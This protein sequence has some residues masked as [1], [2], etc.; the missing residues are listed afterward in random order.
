MPRWLSRNSACYEGICY[1]A[2]GRLTAIGPVLSRRT[3]GTA[4]IPGSENST[5]HATTSSER[6]QFSSPRPY[7]SS[8]SNRLRRLALSVRRKDEDAFKYVL[9]RIAKHWTLEMSKLL[10]RHNPF[11][12]VPGC[13]PT[14]PT[15]DISTSDLG[16]HNHIAASHN[17]SK[18]VSKVR[19]VHSAADNHDP[20]NWQ[21]GDRRPDWQNAYTQSIQGVSP[22]QQ[23]IDIAAELASGKYSMDD[24][25]AAEA[26][27]DALTQCSAQ[28]LLT[29]KEGPEAE[30]WN[31][32]VSAICKKFQNLASSKVD[33]AV[34]LP[35]MCALSRLYSLIPWCENVQDTCNKVFLFVETRMDMLNCNQMCSLAHA[36]ANAQIRKAS[37]TTRVLGRVDQFASSMLPADIV[38][39]SMA[40][41]S[42]MSLDDHANLLKLGSVLSFVL[43]LDSAVTG[44]GLHTLTELLHQLWPVRE[45]VSC[46]TEL[47]AGLVPVLADRISMAIP[48][49]WVFSCLQNFLR[50][51]PCI[52]NEAAS[53]R[54][55]L[56]YFLSLCAPS[57]S[58]EKILLSAKILSQDDRLSPPYL[59]PNFYTSVVRCVVED[60]AYLSNTQLIDLL[61]CLKVFKMLHYNVAAFVA[62]STFPRAASLSADEFCQLLSVLEYPGMSSGLKALEAALGSQEKKT[63]LSACLPTLKLNFR[64]ALSAFLMPECRRRF[65]ELSDAEISS[66]MCAL[67]HNNVPLDILYPYLDRVQATTDWNQRLSILYIVSESS[68]GRTPDRAFQNIVTQAC[69]AVLDGLEQNVEA[70]KVVSLWEM[71]PT[72]RGLPS[73]LL[74]HLTCQLLTIC[75]TYTPKQSDSSKSPDLFQLRTL[76][77]MWCLLSSQATPADQDTKSNVRQQ[78]PSYALQGL[79]HQ[80]AVTRKLSSWSDGLREQI[81]EKLLVVNRA[82]AEH[83]SCPQ[84]SS[85]AHSMLE[86]AHQSSG[87]SQTDLVKES[88]RFLQ[89]AKAGVLNS[90][91]KCELLSLAGLVK[92]LN[93]VEKQSKLSCN[94]NYCIEP[95]LLNA[96][97]SQISHLYR[98]GSCIAY[99][100]SAVDTLNLLSTMGPLPRA[101]WTVFSQL[102]A[103]TIHYFPLG[104]VVNLGGVFIAQRCISET[105]VERLGELMCRSG[106]ND[107]EP[108]QVLSLPKILLSHSWPNRAH[109]LQ[110]VEQA[111]L[112][113][114]PTLATDVSSPALLECI[115][116]LSSVLYRPSDQFMNALSS[117]L[118]LLFTPAT[119]LHDEGLL[120]QCL[121]FFGEL[122]HPV[123]KLFTPAQHYVTEHIMRSSSLDVAAILQ[124]PRWFIALSLCHHPVS[125]KMLSTFF[126]NRSV[127]KALRTAPSSHSAWQNLRAL[128]NRMITDG[129]LIAPLFPKSTVKSGQLHTALLSAHVR[130][131]EGY[132]NALNKRRQSGDELLISID[133]TLKACLRDD[134]VIEKSIV[135]ESLCPVWRAFYLDKEGTVCQPPTMDQI[136]DE[137]ALGRLGIP[138]DHIPAKEDSSPDEDNNAT[139]QQ[140]AGDVETLKCTTSTKTEPLSSAKAALSS[141]TFGRRLPPAGG[142][143]RFAV[144]PLYSGNQCLL[145][146]DLP[147][148]STR[149]VER[150]LVSERWTV[151]M[152][153]SAAWISMSPSERTSMIITKAALATKHAGQS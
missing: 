98:N 99:P 11:L 139:R 118:H 134:R 71:L 65:H 6:L 140:L 14:T 56:H 54:S 61:Q 89:L 105:Y 30:T 47:A 59:H 28:Q 46:Y 7:T 79:V 144:L 69:H 85:I 64:P 26:I 52:P 90:L 68:H 121:I 31:T 20:S 44:S 100:V 36:L 12:P 87:D 116:S 108:T 131:A 63:L 141:L 50:V 48:E 29:L 82:V 66:M 109:C 111:I 27:T 67:A 34:T 9:G 18:H 72:L 138:C 60:I 15:L 57:L 78:G 58:T 120:L 74:M 130:Y 143:T 117:H 149:V 62:Q 2:G 41:L 37:A 49:P 103:D 21:N 150:L 22:L 125:V 129:T 92:V 8:V 104:V 39:T 81:T 83:L 124:L 126:K 95:E 80:V 106:V 17:H 112:N 152:I 145:D 3:S 77:K 45:T 135:T 110:L 86:L 40:L 88:A 19:S 146:S 70:D 38:N 153:P 115:S 128:S 35:I 132:L 84:I 91:L 114:L 51:L 23:A 96:V 5:H 119:L 42:L 32:S 151:L 113:L 136:S 93:A 101:T 24:V 75:T 123:G 137:D 76:D 53:L 25:A 122:L 13:A 55:S 142:G 147:S 73:N 97:C 4:V 127:Q 94:I 1:K 148:A 10:R 133:M 102:V 16:I 33:I 107:L 43:P